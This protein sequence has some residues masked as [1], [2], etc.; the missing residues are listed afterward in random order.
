M[1][2]VLQKQIFETEA[3]IDTLTKEASKF[4]ESD[5]SQQ[6]SKLQTNNR[7]ETINRTA[8]LL[9]TTTDKITDS[10]GNLTFD[11]NSK[12]YPFYYINTESI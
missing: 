10:N 1:I 5:P 2:S 12:N 8:E 9:G 11:D 6:T 7:V 3:K 4:I